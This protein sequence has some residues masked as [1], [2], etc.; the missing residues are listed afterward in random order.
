MYIPLLIVAG[1]V[2]LII[3]VITIGIHYNFKRN[4][5]DWHKESIKATDWQVEIKEIPITAIGTVD[6]F[7]VAL[8]TCPVPSRKINLLIP[9][10]TRKLSDG[11]LLRLSRSKNND[12]VCAYED[13]IGK[14][15]YEPRLTISDITQ[16]DGKN[17]EYAIN[18]LNHLCAKH[19]ISSSGACN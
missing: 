13:G 14:I 7:S 4:E 8:V 6:P 15:S 18:L 17:R 11:R 12:E 5:P 3:V 1:A 19:N 2:V 16:G 10:F 9:T